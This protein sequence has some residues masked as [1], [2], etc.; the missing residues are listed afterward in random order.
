M[1]DDSELI[2]GLLSSAG[3]RCTQAGQQ[4]LAVFVAAPRDALSHAEIDLALQGNGIR[5]NRVTLYRLLGRLKHA[6]VLTSHTGEDRITRFAYVPEAYDSPCAS[7]F[8]CQSCHRIRQ[9]KA[10]EA[11]TELLNELIQDPSWRDYQLL[12]ANLTISGICAECRS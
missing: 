9:S 7:Y 3:L 12:N 6:G 11:L 8:E 10:P 2:R 5:L 1:T 4:L